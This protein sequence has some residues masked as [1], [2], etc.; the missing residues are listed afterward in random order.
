MNP[1]TINT[2]EAVLH[3]QKMH[4]KINIL[5]QQVLSA[6]QNMSQANNTYQNLASCRAVL[7]VGKL[8]NLYGKNFAAGYRV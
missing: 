1:D 3:L 4:F 2:D 8:D 7:G 6:I 5:Q